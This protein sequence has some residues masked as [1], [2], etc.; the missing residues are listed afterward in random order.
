MY[1][2]GETGQKFMNKKRSDDT[3]SFLLVLYFHFIMVA[4]MGNLMLQ[5]YTIAKTHQCHFKHV[6]TGPEGLEK[7]DKVKLVLLFSCS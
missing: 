1:G 4:F 6:L 3:S 2:Q 7:C 5:G